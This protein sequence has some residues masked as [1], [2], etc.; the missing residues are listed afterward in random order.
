MRPLPYLCWKASRHADET[1]PS[2]P[3]I[4]IALPPAGAFRLHIIG[5]PGK[6]DLRVFT[7]HRA[8]QAFLCPGQDGGHI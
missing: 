2:K 7:E 4:E 6:R 5:F 3:S 1:S 8:G